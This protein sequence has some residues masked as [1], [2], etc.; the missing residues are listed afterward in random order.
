MAELIKMLFSMLSRVD[1]G[2]HV[3]DGDADAPMGRGTF[4]GVYGPLQSIQFW[5]LQKR[6]D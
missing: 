4:R 6:L 3:L 2:N 5:G 1:P